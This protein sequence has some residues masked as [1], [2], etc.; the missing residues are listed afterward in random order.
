M[1]KLTAAAAL[2]AATLATPALA[3][4]LASLDMVPYATGLSQPVVFVQH[5][6]AANTF[7]VVQQ[8]GL[9]RVVV[10]G[11][12][13]AT[14][15]MSLVGQLSTGGERGFLG[16]A[17]DPNYATNRRF[18]VNFTNPSG[19]T[20]I[21]RFQ[22]QA[23]NPLVADMGTR[24]DFVFGANAFITQPFS[25]HNGGNIMFGPDGMLHIGMGDG[26]SA[27]DPGNRAQNPNEYLGK[28]LRLD[29]NVPDANATGYAIPASNPFVDGLP[30]NALHQIWAFGVRN[31]WKW[32]FD[33]FGFDATNGLLIADVGQNAVEEVNY[34]SS[35]AGGENYGWKR[36][37]GNNLFSATP[38]AYEPHTGP[39]HTYTH[40][41]GFSI[42]G[43]FMARGSRMCSYH[44]RYFFADYVNRRVWSFELTPA[45]TATDVVEHTADLLNGA[46]L[47]NLSAFGR[48]RTGQ[49]YICGYSNGTI[50]RIV[51]NEPGLTG[52]LDFNGIVEFAD[53]N[54][55]LGEYG[56]T[57]VFEDLNNLL[58]NYGQSCP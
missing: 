6:T 31:P 16:L 45:G 30:I 39:I 38:L 5:P 24:K 1:R 33:D 11:V 7:I 20:V 28:M 49:L 9:A 47:P 55:L 19:H 52:D 14:N 51:S 4:A 36:F 12:V 44:G 53:L 46:Q 37:E 3:G 48:D 25:N 26:G 18:Y 15:F 56:T 50:Y 54:A 27:N 32:S 17:F 43:G 35:M 29:V 13:Q 41:V 10:N 21:A 40:A 57:Y 58:G 2:A 34:V 8:G 42:T 22:T 23:G